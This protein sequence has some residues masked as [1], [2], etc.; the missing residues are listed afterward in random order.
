MRFVIRKLLVRKLIVVSFFCS[1]GQCDCIE[2]INCIIFCFAYNEF[3]LVS[4]QKS[5]ER[6]KILMIAHMC[7]DMIYVKG[8]CE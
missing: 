7:S 5:V 4:V 3:T 1:L 6:K 2:V 8:V